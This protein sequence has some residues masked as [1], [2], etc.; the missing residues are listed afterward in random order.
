M[1]ITWLFIL[2]TESPSGVSGTMD[3]EALAT[4]MVVQF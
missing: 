1:C 4:F 2:V 3:E